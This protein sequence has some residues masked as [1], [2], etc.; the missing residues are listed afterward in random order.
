MCYVKGARIVVCRKA[1][2]QGKLCKKI[3]N[4]VKVGKVYTLWHRKQLDFYYYTITNI[5][6][7]TLEAIAT[8]IHPATA[9]KHNICNASMS[10][11]FHLI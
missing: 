11:T 8:L 2:E 5:E 10:V 7:D 1:L 3:A 6:D 4:K 9:Q